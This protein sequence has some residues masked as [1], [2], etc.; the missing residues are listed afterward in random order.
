MGSAPACK[1]STL[2][3]KTTQPGKRLTASSH[4]AAIAIQPLNTGIIRECLAAQ[5]ITNTFH[6]EVL[7]TVTSTN[8]YLAERRHIEGDEIGV[9]IADQQTQ[10]KGRFGHHWWSPPGVNLYL[11][12]Q[13]NLGQWKKQYEVLGL[14]LLIG[15]AECLEKL[16]VVGVRLKWPNDIC[17]GDN[18]LGGVLIERKAGQMQNNLII[19][20]GLNVAMSQVEEYQKVPGW[21]DLI[22]SH[23]H[24]KLCRNELAANV[25]ASLTR[26][27]ETLD[28]KD[29]DALCVAWHRYDLMYDRKVEFLYQ[30]RRMQ[31]MAH[32]I[33]AEGRLVLQTDD[34]QLSLHSAHV[35]ELRL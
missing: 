8:T 35:R 11:S 25:I 10:G 16:G 29:A 6:I 5:G 31:G 17:V 20:V 22:S 9:C 27:L 14:W 3:H 24:W 23:P 1:P 15:L 21:V 4:N 13:W 7:P 34:E 30:G 12:M 26:I 19:G 18:K 32:G 33:D 2:H 28:E